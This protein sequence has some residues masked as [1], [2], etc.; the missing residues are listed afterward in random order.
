VNAAESLKQ[1]INKGEFVV[2][3]GVGMGTDRRQLETILARDSYG[4]VSVDS[5]HSPFS[6]EKLVQFCGVAGEAGI[7]VI[8]RI[9]HTR[10]T[11]LIGNLLDLGPA[12][13][14]VPQV[15]TVAT[16]DEAVSYFYYPQT[17]IRS[18]GGAAR[19][20]VQGRQDRL[21][22]SAWWNA[23]GVLWM[24]IESINAVTHARTLAKKGVDCLSWGPADLS[25]SR[26][27]NPHHPLKTDDDCVK[28]VVKVLD[29][30]GVRLCV[31]SYDPALRNKYR[32]MG[33]TILLE[34]PKT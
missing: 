29:G 34:R 7:P 24:Q 20:K 1:R 33:V 19:W 15:E 13:V 22:Y 30:S 32:D 31:R 10:H 6:E 21:D 17:G 5:Q 2:G 11:Y 12:G 3:V 23:H 4:Y 8:L 18:W 25:F 14:E 27:A 9:K 28:Y 26:E 16:V